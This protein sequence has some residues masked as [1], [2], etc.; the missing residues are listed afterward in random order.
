MT[1]AAARRVDGVR[2]ASADIAAFLD[3]S[4]TGPDTTI[5]GV[6]ALD[7]AGDDDLAFC[8][9]DDPDRIRRSDAGVV[10]CPAATPELPGRSLVYSPRPKFDFVRVAREFFRRPVEATQIHPTAV[11]A[12]GAEVGER[13]RI[14]PNAYV[15]DAVRIGDGCTIG[16]G[17]VIGEPGFGFVRDESGRPLRQPH[18]GTVVLED[19]V[20]V[21][22][23]ASIDRA[24]FGETV[25]REGAKL[26]GNVHVA[27]HAEIGPDVT[28]AAG[29]C[30]AGGSTIEAR[31]EVHPNVTVATDVSVG[32]DAEV[33]ANSAV[34]DDV[35]PGVAVAGSPAEVIDA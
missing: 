1:G 24:A 2:L 12:D 17:A 34:L 9:Y 11:V 23:N 35:P 18:R 33:G 10:V 27:H 15:G 32:A 28:V 25:L 30:F 16:A 3:A 29:C 14:G 20:A 26:S 7:R 5:S 4:R 13:C 19:D 6:D 31:V 8:V 21:G 22:A